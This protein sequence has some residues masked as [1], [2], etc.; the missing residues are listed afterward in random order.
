MSTDTNQALF[1]LNLAT[2]KPRI[3]HITSVG[4]MSYKLQPYSKVYLF[5]FTALHLESFQLFLV[6]LICCDRAGGMCDNLRISFT[7]QRR[8][9]RPRRNRPAGRSW[10]QE[11]WKSLK[12]LHTLE[13]SLCCGRR[14]SASSSNCLQL[15]LQLGSGS[16]VNACAWNVSVHQIKDNTNIFQHNNTNFH[17]S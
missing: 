1:F 10:H 8:P 4:L 3:P 7:V 14:G 15:Y 5:L 17:I 13:T 6:G 16:S 9:N 2:G 12:Q 11:T